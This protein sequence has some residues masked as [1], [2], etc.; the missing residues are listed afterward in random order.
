MSDI[1]QPRRLPVP[2]EANGM[3]LDRFLSKWFPARSRSSLARSIKSGRVT[4]NGGGALRSST[5]LRTGQVLLI[6]IP[7]IAPTTPPP[8][9]PPVL[10]E[11]DQL[12]ALNKPAGMLC[13]P[14]GGDFKWAII[15]LARTH[16]KS[17]EIDLAHR[18]DRETSGVL[19]LT[20]T[21]LSNIRIK[22]MFKSG[23]IKK[24]YT[25]LCRGDLSWNKRVIDTP[26][27]PEGGK[28]R[29]KMAA[30]DDG[31]SA[32]T[33]AT[34]LERSSSGMTM[35]SCNIGSGRTHQIRVHLDHIGASIIGDKLYGVPPDVFLDAWEHGVGDSVIKRA[36]APRQALHASELII[37]TSSD[38][39]IKIESALPADMRRWW[40]TP[41]TLPFD[42]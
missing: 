22:A 16:W 40:A 25:A 20:K 4:L 5:T 23:Q 19:L 37:P 27:G 28:I 2:D 9:L 21:A 10:F 41:E 35:V 26:I 11:D 8:P 38:H 17:T 18:L 6:S 33:T 30:R 34:V 29:I 32:I 39:H 3:R 24:R 36:G 14:A 13:H 42:R 15:G 12:I 1:Y 7:G 31:L